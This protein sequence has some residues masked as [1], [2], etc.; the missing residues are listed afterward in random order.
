MSQDTPIPIKAVTSAARALAKIHEVSRG[1]KIDLPRSRNIFTEMQRALAV[2]SDIEENVPGGKQ[3]I[4]EVKEYELWAKEYEFTPV[5]VHNDYRVGNILF[6]DTEEVTAVIDFDWCCLGPAIKDVAHT[7][8]EWSLPDKSPK[9]FK[10]VFEAFLKAYN[11]AVSDPIMDDNILYRWI[12]F[13]ALSDACTYIVDRLNSGE[14]KAIGSCY[15]YRKF[16][17]FK[18]MILHRQSA[19]KMIA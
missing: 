3:F 4:K 14:I 9:H 17:Y 19:I 5:L 11:G 12:C 7:L 6:D 13:V 2:A 16:E 15:M 18:T 1:H 10:E 8:I